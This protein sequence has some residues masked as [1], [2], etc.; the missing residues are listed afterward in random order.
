MPARIPSPILK[1]TLLCA[2]AVL[3]A[4]SEA[5]TPQD[6]A[7]FVTAEDLRGSG[8]DVGK[9]A[10][11]LSY[12]KQAIPYL[13]ESL[14]YKFKATAA[15]TP[16]PV[17]INTTVT[18]S[19]DAATARADFGAVQTGLR[20]GLRIAGVA[21]K[22]REDFYRFGDES[23]AGYLLKDNKLTGMYF[24]TRSGRVTYQYLMFGLY[25]D[26]GAAFG[27]FIRVHLQRAAHYNKI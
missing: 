4:C 14:E 11:Q 10:P 7:L 2:V 13:S 3:S 19:R 17:V 21:L 25:F 5:V 1:I 8:C 6:K 20:I 27:R 18:I 15:G 12:T 24:V 22:A 9:V 26:E 16:C 23:A